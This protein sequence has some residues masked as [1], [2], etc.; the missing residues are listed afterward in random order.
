MNVVTGNG[1][2]VWR[3]LIAMWLVV[4]IVGTLRGNDVEDEEI[5][6]LKAAYLYKLLGYAEWPADAFAT[7]DTPFTVGLVGQGPVGTAFA[8]ATRSRSAQNRRIEVRP[9]Q[10]PSEKYDDYEAAVEK[11]HR[12]LSLCHVIYVGSDQSEHVQVLLSALRR[13][14]VLLVSDTGDFAKKGGMVELR[15]SE[16]EGRLVFHINLAAA[17][18]ARISISSDLLRLAT[19][20]GNR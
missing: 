6:Q 9:F 12:E 4:A 17:K 20:V 19:V 5:V 1:K 14:S 7:P 8:E 13:H 18:E 15:L 10:Y 2:L 16:E 11:L 3:T